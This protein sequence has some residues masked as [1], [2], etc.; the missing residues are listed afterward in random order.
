MP[1]NEPISLT[2]GWAMGSDEPR[3]GGW[4]GDLMG[5]VSGKLVTVLC[6]QSRGI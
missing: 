6:N 3:G 5:R 2:D 4:G 1:D